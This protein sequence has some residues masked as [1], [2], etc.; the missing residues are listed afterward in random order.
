MGKKAP[1]VIGREKNHKPEGRV[2]KVYLFNVT[3]TEKK[4]LEVKG[5]KALKSHR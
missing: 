3:L 1:W 4:A 2:E 5:T